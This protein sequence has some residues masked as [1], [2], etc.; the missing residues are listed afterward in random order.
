MT[1]PPP[2]ERKTSIEAE[3]TKTPDTAQRRPREGVTPPQSQVIS[4]DSSPPQ[5]KELTLFL[6]YR[7]KIKKFVLTDGYEEL[8]IARLQLAFIEKFAWNTQHDGVELPE[9][10]VQ[11]P[12][13]GVR[14]EL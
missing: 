7:S 2:P 9:I 11:D 12:V 1:A 10:Y 5:G 13:S 6:Q 4:T 14:H 3:P 8:T